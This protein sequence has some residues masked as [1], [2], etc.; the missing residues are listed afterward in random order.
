[1]CNRPRGHD[2]DEHELRDGK[3]FVVRVRWPVKK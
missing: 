1:V 2:G 3:T